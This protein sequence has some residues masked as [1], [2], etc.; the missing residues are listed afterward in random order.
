MQAVVTVAQEAEGMLCSSHWKD[1]DELS[2]WRELIACVIGSR[3]Q[4]E[5]AIATLLH[6]ESKGLL[7]RIDPWVSTS[8]F[9][10]ELA[11]ALEEP[12]RVRRDGVTS[13]MRY[14]FPQ[15]R[16]NHIRRTAERISEVGGIRRLLA[17]SSAPVGARRHLVDLC[18]G[19]GPKQSSLFLRNVG[20]AEDLAVLD[21]HVVRYLRLV[22]LLPDSSPRLSDLTVYETVEAIVR[23]HSED[24]GITMPALDI[25]VWTV[26]RVAGNEVRQW[27]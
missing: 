2:L 13:S 25:A 12:L 26:M 14:R 1:K 23:S 5:V 19:I 20:Y 9:E 3:V 18:V 27:R 10:R 7:D 15:S 16:A 8:A 21:V 22:C 17:S 6:L 11:R 4:Y 24:L